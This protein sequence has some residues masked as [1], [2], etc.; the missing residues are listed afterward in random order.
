MRLIFITLS[1]LFIYF[2]VHS[3]TIKFKIG[4]LD[5]K[6]DIRYS[7][8]GR[9]PVDIRSNYKKYERPI[10][11]DR[12]G[13]I[14]SKKFERITKT[15]II[16]DHF[17]FKDDIELINFLNSVS[18]DDYSAILLDL[19][20]KAF[21]DIQT[22]IKDKNKIIFFNISNSYNSLRVESCLNNLY[23]TFPSD[24]MKTDAAAQFL[25]QKKWNKTLLLRGP[26]NEDVELSKSFKTSAKKFGVKIVEE[27]IFVNSNDPR[28]RERNDLSFLTKGKRFKSIFISDI[29]GEFALGVPYSTMNP[30]A[31]LGSSGLSPKAWHWSY[32]RHGAPQVNGRFE[33][34]FNRRM[35]DADWASWIA[36]KSI[37]ESILRTKSTDT[38]TI[39]NFLVSEEF[40]VDGSKGVS[41]NYRSTTNQLRQTILLV[42]SNNWVTAI[43]PL[44]SFKNRKNNLETLGVIKKEKKC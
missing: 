31:V 27:K 1:L 36:I 8:W 22:S 32:M 17:R 30:V 6:N 21:K 41:L 4:F 14:D 38:N 19:N 23:H 12:L 13:V 34:N 37:L 7:D 29:D 40:N 11:G 10:D 18:P 9:H 25:V 16:L 33:R 44:E 5:L 2:S 39:K 20:L 42:G 3:E 43:A 35:N 26:L 24:M 28:V 15:E